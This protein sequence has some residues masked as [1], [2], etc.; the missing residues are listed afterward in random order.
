MGQD[1]RPGHRQAVTLAGLDRHA[2]SQFVVQE[3]RPG[4]GGDDK[5]IRGKFT[6]CRGSGQDLAVATAKALETAVFADGNAAGF[7]HAPPGLHQLVGPEV[8]VVL[9]EPAAGKPG[10]KC[11][12]EFCEGVAIIALGHA[13]E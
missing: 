2:A 7:E 3:G 12:L 13:L 4:T 6:V 10:S 1:G 9:V 11:R 8:G 5:E